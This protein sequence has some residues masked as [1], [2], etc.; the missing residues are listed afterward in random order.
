MTAS[1]SDRTRRFLSRL[2]PGA[3]IDRAGDM[4]VELT[5]GSNNPCDEIAAAL[6]TTLILRL[7]D[8]APIVHLRGPAGRSAAIPRLGQGRL[9][10]E[11]A[12]EHAGFQS[13]SS[14]T[15]E[16]AS[17]PTLRFSFGQDRGI[18]VSS[19]GWRVALGSPLAGEGNEFAAAFAG[20]LAANE[21]L[22]AILRQFGV[23][24]SPFRGVVSL[25]DLA[26]DGIDGPAVP[27]V[28]DLDRLAFAA[29]GGVASAAAWALSLRPL[30][31]GP[32]AVDPDEIDRDSTNLNRHLTASM[33][34]LGESKATLLANLLDAAG[35][36]TIVDPAS[37][38]ASRGRTA[39]MVLASPDNDAVRREVQLDLPRS[40]ISAGTGDDGVYTVSR[41]NFVSGACLCCIA[42]A[43]LLDRDPLA[44]AARRLGVRVSILAPHVKSDEPLPPELV[45]EMR[46]DDQTRLL[47][48][49][50]AGSDL[51]AA[52]CGTIPIAP[53][54]P[55]LSAPTLAA[56]PGVLAAVEVV[57]ELVEAPVPL[58]TSAT[59]L[60]TSVRTGPHGRWLRP[61]AKRIGCVCTDQLYLDRHHTKWRSDP[62]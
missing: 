51:M 42:R 24:V 35:A 15:S 16:P 27:A 61:R 9:I 7:D 57:K 19:A 22:Q 55:A 5:I 50:I 32:V 40:I 3:T 17:E 31:G 47:L 54:G 29:C 28:L 45:A 12:N 49:G 13:V 14:L 33:R 36:R 1:P 37:W 34:N 10:D 4:R 38:S 23:S 20:V 21:V 11:L 59:S 41:H 44:A 2:A 56:A 26:L 48:A 53:V 60:I 18:A 25:W 8:L 46:I 30:R 52:M 6:A 43:D 39:A 58:R 62:T